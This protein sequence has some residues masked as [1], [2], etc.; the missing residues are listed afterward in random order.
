MGFGSVGARP[1]ALH[2]GGLSKSGKWLEVPLI[3]N[4]TVNTDYAAHFPETMKI[5]RTQCVDATGLAL[6]GGGDVI[7]S[8]L[9]PGTRLRPHCGPSNSR[10]TCH[11]GVRVPRGCDEG[12]FLRVAGKLALVGRKVAALFLMIPLN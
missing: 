11:L 6:C 7:F 10:L 12:C 3:T 8:V 9:T 2:D 1:G 4:C 5:L